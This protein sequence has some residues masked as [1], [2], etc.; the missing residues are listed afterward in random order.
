[1]VEEE[2]SYARTASA[3][4]SDFLSGAAE[5]D[6]MLNGIVTLF[7]AKLGESFA[8]P[9]RDLGLL[10]QSL[11]GFENRGVQQ[12]VSVLGGLQNYGAPGLMPGGGSG[13]IGGRSVA[14]TYAAQAIQRDVMREFVD[15]ITGAP[16]AEAYGLNQAQLGQAAALALRSGQQYE[17]G[18]LFQTKEVTESY[19]MR[20]I[21]EGEAYYEKTGDDSAVLEAE[22]LKVG[23]SHTTLD[24]N[25]KRRM[26][27]M[28]SDAA[29]TL[30]AIRD[31]M[32]D[33]AL[34]DLENTIQ[35]L[36]G[37]DISKFGGRA[38]R[39]RMSQ[40]QAIS[41]NYG[42]GQEGVQRA[43]AAIGASAATIGSGNQS[44]DFHAAI[45]N[46]RMALAGG[47][48]SLM[49]AG[50]A[51]G[52]GYEA[53]TRTHAQYAQDVG[54]QTSQILKEEN[55]LLLAESALT[56]A[57]G[58]TDQQKEE[59]RSIHR[60]MVEA[61]S[62][63]E[64]VNQVRQRAREFAERI[65]PGLTLEDLG[66]QEAA[67]SKLTNEQTQRMGQTAATTQQTRNQ[68]LLKR[69][70]EEDSTYY[71]LG[72]DMTQ[73][74]AGV[75]GVSI[76]N[77][78]PLLRPEFN[79]LLGIE[80]KDERA[81]AMD[82]FRARNPT[83]DQAFGEDADEFW[84]ISK[85][86]KMNARESEMFAVAPSMLADHKG[87][88]PKGQV[89]RE[90]ENEYEQFV[91][92]N[93]QG[94]TTGEEFY[95][96]LLKGLHGTRTWTQQ[97]KLNEIVATGRDKMPGFDMK[98]GKLDPTKENFNRLRNE[99]KPDELRVLKSK[100]LNID[101]E[102]AALEWMGR[103]E[104]TGQLQEVLKGS[105]AKVTKLSLKDDRIEATSDNISKLKESLTKEERSMLEQK[106]WD[107]DNEE[108]I[109]KQL[110]N[111]EGQRDVS[112]ILN[113]GKRALSMFEGEMI[114]T[115]ESSA[116]AAEERL[117]EQALMK[118][119]K[120]VTGSSIERKA[121]ES[122]EDYRLRTADEMKKSITGDAGRAK[123]LV[124]LAAY[125]FGAKGTGGQAYKDLEA[126][127]EDPALA[128]DDVKTT[129]ASQIKTQKKNVEKLEADYDARH[130][131][132]LN[133][134]GPGKGRYVED[135]KEWTHEDFMRKKQD[136]GRISQGLDALSERH[137]ASAERSTA[138]KGPVTMHV[139]GPVSINSNSRPTASS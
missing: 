68:G 129:I 92:N 42:E 53:P 95:F 21:L 126:I 24:A 34:K 65:A 39:I 137:L 16:A 14:T 30:G 91:K 101:D 123:E 100:G 23:S 51:R 85:S 93:Q 52:M 20:K 133:K 75:Y 106:G 56:M 1:M 10:V 54:G 82:E 86:G 29:S 121:G 32:G 76:A 111:P 46:E 81:K 96:E 120:K 109:K 37:G 124:R 112:N 38:A 66:G 17:Q 114:Y 115:D 33:P 78:D 3:L 44:L 118:Q 59:I 105:R 88:V 110:S 19:R 90:A 28:I 47:R 99:L 55:D 11:M 63:P 48:A 45:Y 94:G 108:N 104:S 113:S 131:R 116:A 35:K 6:S 8:G 57:A 136:L 43:V 49:N 2:K 9:L 79:K 12:A 26:K 71:T 70:F 117:N 128:S 27:E 67:M 132:F 61:G 98:D 102:A 13:M 69:R 139:A 7:T 135:G 84:R 5:Q 25:G 36:F 18:N 119:S 125:D 74:E 4:E 107:F 77:M 15:P 130:K 97:E 64:R 134:E 60:A 83:M 73:K 58:G 89:Y 80:D 122:D 127:M 40:I 41:P 87:F 31:V 72:E 103:A 138:H 22:A 62:D 50:V